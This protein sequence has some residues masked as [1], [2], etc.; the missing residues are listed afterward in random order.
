MSVDSLPRMFVLP[1]DTQKAYV[2]SRKSHS[3]TTL[4]ERAGHVA[5]LVPR[6][7]NVES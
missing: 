4:A 2:V 7:D 3:A 1:F 5:H 6:V